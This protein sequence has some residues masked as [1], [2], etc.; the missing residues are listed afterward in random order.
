MY[1]YG[2]K[3][4]EFRKLYSLTQIDL[5]QIL[6]MPQGNYSRLEKGEQDIKL[7]M[8]LLICERLNV[9]PNWL[10]ENSH[11][12]AGDLANIETQVIE[13]KTLTHTMEF[14][15]DKIASKVGAKEG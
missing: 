8:I 2:E 4:K 10:L 9:S 12:D 6:G 1:Y 5:A 15:A 13:F 7:S 14:D 11:T 3:L